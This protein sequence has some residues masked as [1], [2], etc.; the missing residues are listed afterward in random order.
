MTTCC[1]GLPFP[2]C[3]TIALIRQF[4]SEK[5]ERLIKSSGAR[6]RC[7]PCVLSMV[8]ISTYGKRATLCGTF[9]ACPGD[10]HMPQ[11]GCVPQTEHRAL[12]RDEYPIKK[13]TKKHI[14]LGRVYG[15]PKPAK[16]CPWKEKKIWV[17]ISEC[18]WDSVKIHWIST[19]KKFRSAI[20]TEIRWIWTIS[21][22]L[23]DPNLQWMYTRGSETCLMS[24][25]LQDMSCT[26]RELWD[27][28]FHDQELVYLFLYSRAGI[29][30]LVFLSRDKKSTWIFVF[31]P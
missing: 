31:P 12:A 9:E 5:L 3:H 21:E 20:L 28:I 2:G 11:T 10:G 22:T 26:I 17:W 18:L 15:R 1:V 14:F 4:F 27:R 19:L 13:T 30:R 16:K 24:I 25:F 6:G 23:T 8:R 7:L 29:Y